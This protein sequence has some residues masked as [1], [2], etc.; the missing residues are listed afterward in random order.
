[1]SPVFEAV[2]RMRVAVALLVPA[3]GIVVRGLR[4]GQRARVGMSSALAAVAVMT[5]RD[6]DEFTPVI[7][8]SAVFLVVYGM[9]ALARPAV[10]PGLGKSKRRT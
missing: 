8:W 9:L 2:S 4:D 10:G 5:Q 7:T 1:L 6:G 3:V